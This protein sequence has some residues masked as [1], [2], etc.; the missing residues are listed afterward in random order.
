MRKPTRVALIG[1]ILVVAH[2]LAPV[3]TAHPLGNFTINRYSRLELGIDQVRVRYVIDMAEI[4]TFQERQRMDLDSNGS[5]SEVERDQYLADQVAGLKRNLH[6]VVNG[7]A[8][9]LESQDYQLEFPVG[10]G[11]LQTLRLSLWLSARLPQP[12]VWRV[13]YQD[14]NFAGRLGWQEVLVKTAGNVTLLESSVPMQDI[15]NEL[16][17]YPQDMLQSPPAVNHATFRFAPIHMAVA[18]N[19]PQ[20]TASALP[21][22]ATSLQGRGSDPFTE[23][24][25]MTDF[26]VGAIGVAI[27]IALVWGAAH[28]FSPGHGKT[29]VAAYLVGSRATAR[30]ALFLGATTTMTHTAGVFALGLVT[31]LASRYIVPEQLFPWLETLSGLLLMVLGL[32]M[33]FSRLRRISAHEHAPHEHDYQFDHDHDH[34]HGHD[35]HDHHHSPEAGHNHKH[36]PLGADGSPVT[37]RSLLALGISGGLLPCPSA[38]V[39]ML[40][41][42]ALNRIALGLVLIVVFSLGLAGMLTAIGILMVRAKGL[43]ARAS[44]GDRLLGRFPIN[45]RVIQALPAVSA[46]FILLAGI[47]IVLSALAQTGVFRV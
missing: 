24:I 35:H 46:L 12:A 7:E 9:A 4:P 40:G 45:R 42:I 18:T 20:I 25:T 32:S 34:N 1:F 28:A 39:V 44:A 19:R 38:L 31:L 37:W 41:A 16:R 14:D 3:A 13:G 2:I 6:L 5:I 47:G 36:L 11:G 27:L 17:T 8:L 30:H 22:G 10:Q 21:T 26:S 23:L 29:I 43:I 33:F 15:S